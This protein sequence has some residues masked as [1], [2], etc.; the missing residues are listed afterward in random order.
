[1]SD[2][3][4][5]LASLL[6][7][8]MRMDPNNVC[9]N[10]LVANENNQIDVNFIARNNFNNSAYKNNFGGNNYRPYPT[11]NSYGNSYG[12]AYSNPKSSTSDL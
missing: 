7:K 2:K 8:Q 12:N 5:A 4:D 6:T 1:M 3:I 11:G 10:S 9:L